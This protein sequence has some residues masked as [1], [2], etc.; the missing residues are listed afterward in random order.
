MRRARR[1]AEQ[2]LDELDRRVVGPVQVVEQQRQRPL[3]RRAARAASAARGGSGSAPAPR[4]RRAPVRRMAVRRRG[5]DRAELRAERL[6]PRAGAAWRRGRRARRPRA[7]TAPRARARRRGPRASAAPR[8]RR[9]RRRPPAARSCRSPARRRPRARAS[10]RRGRRR[11][12]VPPSAAAYRVLRGP[13]WRK[14]RAR[15]PVFPAVE[16]FPSTAA[17]AARR[18]PAA[19]M[20][21]L[22]ATTPDH[23]GALTPF[24]HACRRAGHQVL[25]AGAEPL[26][27]ALRFWP[28]ADIAHRDPR[29]GAGSG[30]RRARRGRGC[31]VDPGL[32]TER[33]VPDLVPESL[34]GASAGAV[35]FRDPLAGWAPPVWGEWERPR[36]PAAFVAL[37][38]AERARRA[39]NRGAA[40]RGGGRGSRGSE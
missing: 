27:D 18:E 9:A 28:V 22:F 19:F 36:E 13:P 7:R 31:R 8:R 30:R 25:V 37:D 33:A 10:V 40:Q 20:R 1:A 6:D 3:A 39:A 15:P 32:R 26:T 4:R 24:A 35:R 2:V 11:R 16:G 5:Q 29:L 17:A 14:T 21:L 12:P 38:G 23:Q 34:D